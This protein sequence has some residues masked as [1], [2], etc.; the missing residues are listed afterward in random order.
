MFPVNTVFAFLEPRF[1]TFDQV[2][3]LLPPNWPIA[4]LTDFITHALRRLVREKN[5]SV[6]VK[7]LA[8]AQNLRVAAEVVEKIEGLGPVWES[9]KKDSGVA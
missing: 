6:V 7:A 2:L 4:S 9:N 1:L 3:P 8:S 5:E